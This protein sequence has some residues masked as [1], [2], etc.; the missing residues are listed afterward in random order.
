MI[1]YLKCVIYRMGGLQNLPR[2]D[3]KLCIRTSNMNRKKGIVDIFIPD[4]IEFPRIPEELSLPHSSQPNEEVSQA[5][6]FTY[7]D[8]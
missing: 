2:V 5:L 8:V 4:C 6:K 3:K 1:L 7:C